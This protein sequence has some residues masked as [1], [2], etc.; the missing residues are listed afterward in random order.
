MVIDAPSEWQDLDSVKISAKYLYGLER[1][2]TMLSGRLTGTLALATEAASPVPNF[3]QKNAIFEALECA[4]TLARGLSDTIPLELVAIEAR[5]A[6]N[7][8]QRVSGFDLDEAL[9]DEIFGQF[10]IGK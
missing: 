10:C 5:Q 9:L 6:R 7:A 8:L 4:E 3:R 2:E 1:L